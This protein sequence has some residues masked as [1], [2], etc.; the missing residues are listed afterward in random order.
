M[1]FILINI[2][3]ILFY[4]ILFHNKIFRKLKK[5]KKQTKPIVIEIRMLVI[6]WKCGSDR[7]KNLLMLEL[8]IPVLW[9]LGFGCITRK[10]LVKLFNLHTKLY[11]FFLALKIYKL[12]I[13]KCIKFMSQNKLKKQLARNPDLRNWLL[14]KYIDC[15]LL[16]YFQLFIP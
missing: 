12:Y 15:Q 5:K 2:L 13:L 10:E 8:S 6:F 3:C 7:G 11:N 1:C 4:F 14:K 16:S 9:V